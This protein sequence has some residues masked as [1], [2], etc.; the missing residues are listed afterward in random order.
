M[1]ASPIAFEVDVTI[2]GDVMHEITDFVGMCLD[3][4]LKGS[5]RI[6]DANNC[7]ICIDDVLVDVGNDVVEPKLLTAAFESCRTCVVEIGL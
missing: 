3:D 5:I 2:G 7:P 1:I 6:D 4:Y